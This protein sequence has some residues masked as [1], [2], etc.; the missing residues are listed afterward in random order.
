MYYPT[1]VTVTCISC[2]EKNFF[3]WIT[4]KT[5]KHWI[6]T[7]GNALPDAEDN[8]IGLEQVNEESFIK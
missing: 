8:H 5:E 3:L 1:S 7:L 6:E 4:I 2:K